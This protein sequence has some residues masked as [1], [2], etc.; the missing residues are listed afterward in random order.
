MS[1]AFNLMTADAFNKL[2]DQVKKRIQLTEAQ[3]Q[4]LAVTAIGYSILQNDVQPANRLF[5]ILGRSQRRDSMVQYLERHG[6]IAWMKT[7]DKFAFYKR[8]GLTF[9]PDTLMGLKWYEA[10]KENPIVSEWDLQ[11]EFD[12]FMK[13]VTTKIQDGTI[14]VDNAQLF[15][16][17]NRA[18]A[19][20]SAT[21]HVDAAEGD[22]TSD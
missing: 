18:S 10:K 7:E 4:Q 22:T 20:Y 17:L 19:E 9:N 12:K 6:Q 13:K 3:L 8:E 5:L 14:K 1:K 11:A 16:Y 2:C 15:E 21:Q